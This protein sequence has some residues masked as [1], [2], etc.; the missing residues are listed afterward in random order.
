MDHL[1]MLIIVVNREISKQNFKI[2]YSQC[3]V[4]QRK[5]FV[6]INTKNDKISKLQLT[7]SAVELEYF[8]VLMQMILDSDNYSLTYVRAIN[9]TSTLTVAYTRDSGESVLNQ[10]ISGGY[11]V[12]SGDSIYFGAR[13]IL[14]F[15][16]YLKSCRPNSVCQLCSELAF[17]VRVFVILQICCI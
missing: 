10:W 5:L 1:K 17:I 6:W 2:V 11:F 13:L 4:T 16:L 14:E 9:V 7:Y 8:H 12:K 3:E 15:T